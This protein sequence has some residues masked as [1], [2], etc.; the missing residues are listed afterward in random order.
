[1]QYVYLL[2]IRNVLS[3]K[4]NDHVEY[5][6]KHKTALKTISFFKKLYIHTKNFILMRQIF[7]ETQ[8]A[9]LK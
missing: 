1:M 6:K 7:A 3:V 9:C 5:L 8:A 2:R 4:A